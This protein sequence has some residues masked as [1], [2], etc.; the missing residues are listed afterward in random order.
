MIKRPTS[1]TV[2]AWI[3]IAIGCLST[4]T[5]ML[6]INNPE[7]INMM[8]K[9]PMPIP[10]QYT[11]NFIGLSIMII[12]GIAMLK[13]F[14]WARLLYVTW[15]IL[16]IIIAFFTSPMKAILLPGL[17]FLA[18]VIFFL[19]RPIANEYFKT[20]KVIDNAQLP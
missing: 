7:V 1:I 3:L 6:T 8:K 19:F 11:I 10:L 15:S 4:I 9:S 12:S 20:S 16:G 17:V 18:I 14:N 5:T 2:I 13:G